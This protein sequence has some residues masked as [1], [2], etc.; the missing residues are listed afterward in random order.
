VTPRPPPLRAPQFPW[1]R[2]T[3]RQLRDHGM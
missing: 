3:R 1:H 2:V